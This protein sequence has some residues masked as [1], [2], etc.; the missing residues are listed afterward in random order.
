MIDQDIKSRI[1]VEEF[2]DQQGIALSTGAA[3]EITLFGAMTVFKPIGADLVR[4]ALHLR[5]RVFFGGVDRGGEACHF[6]GR[7]KVWDDKVTEPVKFI[8]FDF[9]HFR[10]FQKYFLRRIALALRPRSQRI[11]D[12]P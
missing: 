5:E 2:I 3:D 12:P 1:Y 7:E 10:L 4:R 9:V 11:R 8:L 6:G